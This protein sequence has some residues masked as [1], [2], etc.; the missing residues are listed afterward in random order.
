MDSQPIR[1]FGVMQV[2]ELRAE[3]WLETVEFRFEGLRNERLI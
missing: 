2:R 1:D 3:R